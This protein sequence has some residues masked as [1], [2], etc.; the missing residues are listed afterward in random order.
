MRFFLLLFLLLS[1]QIPAFAEEIST[2][3]HVHSDNSSG[4]RTLREISEIAKRQGIQAV[5]MTDLLCERYEYGLAPF[6]N[7]V[8]KEVKRPSV[9]DRGVRHYLG[10]I[11]AVNRAV[12]EVLM[13]DAVVATPFYYWSGQFGKE[14]LVLNERGKDF[15][16]M[17][18]DRNGYE[19]L[20]VISTGKSKFNAYDGNQ[21]S[22]PFQE[23]IDYTNRGGGLVFWSH[24]SAEEHMTFNFLKIFNV[25]LETRPS[26][27]NMLETSGYTGMGVYSVEL[28]QVTNP[29]LGLTI[30]PGGLWD[31]LLLQYIEGRRNHPVWAVG[32]VDYNGYEKENN[33]LGAIQNIVEA[34][35]RS[36]E[37]VLES[38]KNGKL[39]LV[40]PGP[41]AR[42]MVLKDFS[43]K[44]ETGGNRVRFELSLSDGGAAPVHLTLVKNGQIIQEFDRPSPV[45]FD[46]L[47]SSE[48]PGTSSYYRVVASTEASDRLL[49]NPV[50][51]GE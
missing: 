39:Y 31:R 16:V 18:L 28:A 21:Y 34:P 41:G 29:G 15:L 17:G 7:L 38:L 1:I 19:N 47:D 49:S 4:R 50:F 46:W 48:A 30:F 2:A 36:R 23:L 43:S 44:R 22:K 10:E 5:V 51:T 9:W 3:V 25:V 12:P 11:E 20:P 27:Q 32:E 26:T 14:P 45:S 35:A 33:N 8:K 13:I 6:R 42:R 40:I 37:A 24:P